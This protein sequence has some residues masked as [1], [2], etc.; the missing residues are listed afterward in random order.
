MSKM[1]FVTI[2]RL[3]RMHIMQIHVTVIRTHCHVSEGLGMKYP[4]A[5]R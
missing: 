5:L 1:V 3:T 4:Y 2:W